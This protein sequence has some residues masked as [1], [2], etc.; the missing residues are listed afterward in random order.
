[1]ST[2]KEIHTNQRCKKGKMET[3]QIPE[4]IEAWLVVLATQSL[5]YNTLSMLYHILNFDNCT[6]CGFGKSVM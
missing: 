4:N 1:M 5:I 6:Q 3:F 2:E